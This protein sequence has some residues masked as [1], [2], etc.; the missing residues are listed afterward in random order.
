MKYS[1]NNF[2]GESLAKDGVV[3]VSRYQ[4]GYSGVQDHLEEALRRLKPISP[5]SLLVSSRTDSGV[6]AFS[7]SAHFDFQRRNNKPPF[8]EDVLVQALN[9]YLRAEQIRVTRAHRVPSDFHARFRA[10]S[11]TYV[12]RMALGVC[13]HTQLPLTE[14]D[15]C[16]G[17]RDKELDV[18]A[19]REAAA[20][21]AGTHDFSSFAAE[22]HEM[23]FKR[24]VRNMDVLSIQ[25]GLS[26]AHSHFHR[27]ISLW[28]LTFRSRSFLYRQV[29]RMT[30]ALV[31][32]GQGRLSVSQLADIL[33]ARDTRAY[34][35]N[36]L[37]PARGLFLTR[38]DYKESDL[39]LS[40]QLYSNENATD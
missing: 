33:K 35:Q 36:M 26:F 24:P 3:G 20:L 14:C 17:L 10:Q 1:S 19:M 30:G 9:F 40:D 6:H 23:V 27:E 7:N 28:E 11:R 38:V 25:P 29:R 12:Y 5:V 15:L 31:A 2:L 22:S 16:W 13:S 8:A 37:A 4:P 39:Q 32:V 34:P 21:L 18:G